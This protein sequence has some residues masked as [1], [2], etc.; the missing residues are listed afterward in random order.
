MCAEDRETY[1]EAWRRCPG[2]F[3]LDIADE[4]LV[5]V[6]G[7]EKAVGRALDMGTHR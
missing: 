1:G 5:D 6:T 4:G 3:A 7:A 2:G